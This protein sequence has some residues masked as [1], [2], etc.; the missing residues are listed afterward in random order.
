MAKVTL[1]KATKD[2][3]KLNGKPDMSVRKSTLLGGKVGLSTNTE[4]DPFSFG[5]HLFTR[6]QAHKLFKD[7]GINLDDWENPTRDNWRNLAEYLADRYHPDFIG[8][9][10]NRRHKHAAY[11]AMLYGNV[12]FIREDKCLPNDKAALQYICNNFPDVLT[13]FKPGGHLRSL[14]TLETDLKRASKY[15][16]DGKIRI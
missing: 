3:R 7:A 5:D 1:S 2:D 10:G 13:G 16:K 4:G 14:S 6:E 15:V 9:V 12:K 8:P 11:L